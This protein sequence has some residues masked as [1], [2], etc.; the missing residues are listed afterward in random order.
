VPLGRPETR[1]EILRYSPAGKCP[2][3]LE[4]DRPVRNSLCRGGGS[5]IPVGR[6]IPAFWDFALI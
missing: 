4:E 2:I 6:R 1:A 5:H 3:L